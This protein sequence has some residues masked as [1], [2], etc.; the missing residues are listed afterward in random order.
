LRRSP[1]D[2]TRA[3][4]KADHGLEPPGLVKV[5][6]LVGD[7]QVGLDDALADGLDVSMPV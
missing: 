5:R 7:P 4:V 6:P 3:R 1:G 2:A